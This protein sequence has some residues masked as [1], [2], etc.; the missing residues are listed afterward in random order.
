MILQR[1]SSK[2]M[3][4][5]VSWSLSTYPKQKEN[6]DL[7]LEA[8]Q[9]IQPKRAR[10]MPRRLS[11]LEKIKLYQDRPDLDMFGLRE[12][13]KSYE[14]MKLLQEQNTK[15]RT[16]RRYSN[17]DFSK[18]R[19]DISSAFAKFVNSFLSSQLKPKQISN[20]SEVIGLVNSINEYKLSNKLQT[21]DAK[22]KEI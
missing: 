4:R 1:D 3:K 21:F 20:T 17:S 11:L 5:K 6:I 2:K 8:K 14:N 22:I 7:D 16:L 18:P 9:T 15:I 19:Q 13:M 12:R 10:N